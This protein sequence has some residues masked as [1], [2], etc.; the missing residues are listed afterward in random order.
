MKIN[1]EKVLEVL[2]LDV[3]LVAATKYLDT[4]LT[5]ELI[6]LG[7]TDIG[8][9]RVQALL[10]KVDDLHPVKVHFIGHLQKNKV[11]QV[12]N[13]IDCLESLDSIKLVDLIEKYRKSPL[14]CFIEV[15][16]GEEQKSGIKLD[17]LDNFINY[18]RKCAKINLLGLMGMAHDTNDLAVIEEDFKLIEDLNKKYNFKYLSIGMSND[19]LI[20]L[21]HGATHIRLGRILLEEEE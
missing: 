18:C 2:K 11:K 15:N 17:L 7:V 4:K 9:N 5:N 19:Y 20:A 1:K 8:E 10:E 13:K 3:T 16:L 6:D 14:D 12:I 21:K